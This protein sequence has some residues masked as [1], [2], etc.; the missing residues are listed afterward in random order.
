MTAPQ[1]FVCRDRVR[2]ADVD[3]VCIMR[4]SAFTRLLE[5]AEQELMRS[6][7]LPYAQ[8]FQN[9]TVWMPRRHLSIEYFA[10]ARIDDELILVTYVSRLGTT[11]MTLNTDIW[12]HSH[13]TLVAAAALV[14]VCVTVDGFEKQPLPERSRELFAPYAM[15][16][17]AGRAWRPGTLLN[18]GH[19]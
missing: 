10:P 8:I 2:W 13:E 4:Y 9:P 5:L 11:S 17:E 3:L 7:G 15:S 6:A 18:S 16:V 1:P 19:D 14:I 12:D